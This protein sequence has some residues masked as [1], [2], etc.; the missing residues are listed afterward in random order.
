MADTSTL[1]SLR[2]EII[3]S[4]KVRSDFLKLKLLICAVVGATALGLSEMGAKAPLALAVIPLACLYVDLLCRHLSLRNY[5]IGR[6]LETSD[7]SDAMIRAYE[8]YYH[9]ASDGWFSLEGL[10]LVGSTG[11]VS[12]IVYFVGMSAL[13]KPLLSWEWPALLFPASS[14]LALIL[15]VALHIYYRL[16][17]RRYKNAR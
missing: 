3:E 2:T 6:F 16:L 12:V 15:S 9:K 1:D 8:E 11:V 4:Q 5:A 10:A 17:R 7:H 14:G 13:D